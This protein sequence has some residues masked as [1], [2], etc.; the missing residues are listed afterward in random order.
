MEIKRR[1][2]IHVGPC[3]TFMFENTT[4]VWY[5]VQEMLRAERIETRPRSSTRSGTYNARLGDSGQLGCCVLVAIDDPTLRERRLREWLGLPAHVY[6]RC[7]GGATVRAT[8]D[9]TQGDGRRVSA[10]QYRASF[11]VD[12]WRPIAVGCDLPGLV[13]ETSLSEAQRD[14]LRRIC[15]PAP[16]PRQPPAVLGRHS[17]MLRRS[18]R[19]DATISAAGLDNPRPCRRRARG[20]TSCGGDGPREV[21]NARNPYTIQVWIGRRSASRNAL[22]PGLKFVVMALA[23]LPVGV[24]GL[25]GDSLAETNQR[26]DGG[27]VVRAAAGRALQSVGGAGAAVGGGCRHACTR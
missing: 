3:L 13:A 22:T 11:H 4:T 15:A 2:R 17:S 1:R 14:A 7:A 24:V 20:T 9:R 19:T 6:L 25:A 8:F 5:Q 12:D 26:S 23:A 10:V 27:D 18:F 16:R 21:T